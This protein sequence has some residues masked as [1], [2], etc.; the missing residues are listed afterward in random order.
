MLCTDS[1]SAAG[2]ECG[3]CYLQQRNFIPKGNPCR[4]LSA[5]TGSIKEL[6]PN[7][8]FF[9]HANPYHRASV[10]QGVF[11]FLLVMVQY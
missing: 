2:S 11:T 4:R 7:S 8:F 1:A 10:R 3:P 6:E 5:K 9:I